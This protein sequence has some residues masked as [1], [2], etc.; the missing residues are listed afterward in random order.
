MANFKQ[1]FPNSCGAVALICA[2]AELDVTQY[3]DGVE[4]GGG[5]GPAGGA[6]QPNV[7][8]EMR[9]YGQ[10]GTGVNQLLADRGYSMPA[11]LAMMATTF[12]LP[13][14]T[15]YVSPGF[16]GTLLT[17]F[18]AKALE[19]AQALGITVVEG[20]MPPLQQTQRALRVVAVMKVLG[21]HYV[22]ERPDG[23]YMDPGDG[24]NFANFDALNSSWL[25]SYADTGITIV[26]T[27]A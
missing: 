24:Q 20:P 25:K 10:V 6:F 17:T 5:T 3:P 26:L 21:L 15:I 19:N 27:H 13:K 1:S 12:G 14:P 18:Y 23:S 9:V 16:Y 4:W 22:L 7:Q 8:A 11:Q 2:L